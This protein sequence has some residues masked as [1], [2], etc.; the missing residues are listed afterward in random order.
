MS[1]YLAKLKALR[2]KRA[3]PGNCQ[4][5]QNSGKL[6][7]DSFDSADGS[8]SSQLESPLT[9]PIEPNTT[10]CAHEPE[11]APE[12]LDLGRARRDRLEERAAI[13]E[14]EEGLPRTE[15]EAA[16]D[17]EVAADIY[18]IRQVENDAAPYALS[19]AALR[20][21]CPGH[22][23]E[24]RWRQAI[25]DA[26]AFITNWG[27]E[28]QALGWMA[29]ELFGLH[30][31]PKLPAPSY[32]RLSRYDETGLVWL[33]R[34]RPVVALTEATAA[35]QGGT[36]VLTYR[37]INKPALGPVGDSLDEWGHRESYPRNI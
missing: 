17:R 8:R 35:I 22:V 20:A 2:E 14:F 37:K 34:N 29:A 5:C 6:G 13:L 15:A 33:L 23:P 4:N 24:D 9:E 32:M 27:A 30:P 31:V 7:F 19:L 1:K 21:Q 3:S 36:A 25:T 28:A 16:A 12:T 11:R 26:T 10:G 18:D